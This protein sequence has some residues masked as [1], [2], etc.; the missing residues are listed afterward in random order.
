[1]RRGRATAAALGLAGAAFG[2]GSAS[3]GCAA[4]SFEGAG[5]VA[6]E[7]DARGYDIGVYWKDP[8]GNAYGGLGRLAESLKARGRTLAFAMNGGM[9][10][11]DLSPVGLFVENGETKRRANTRDGAGNFHLKPNGVFWVG[12][13][14]AGV[15]ETSRW[16]ARPPKARFATQSGPMLVIDGRLHPRIS[17]TGTSEKIRN[18][19]GVRDSG[20]VVFA[21]SDEPVTFYAFA[22]LFRDGLNAPNALFLDGSVSTIYSPDVDRRGEFWSVGP[23]IGV[24]KQAP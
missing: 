13:G 12:E 18:G 24:T 11:Q 23:I 2:V 3:A 19:V 21:I 8:D 16:L 7:F 15:E 10:Q 9:F 6:C 17:P 4:M 5:Y 1:M 22:R 20:K 14:S